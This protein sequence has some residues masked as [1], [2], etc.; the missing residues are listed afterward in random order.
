MGLIDNKWA[1]IQVMA[2]RRSGD[3]PLSAPML[4]QF[5]DAY[6]WHSG[7]MSWTLSHPVYPI[8][9]FRSI[10][11]GR[12]FADD[13]FKCIYLNLINVWMKF[14]WNFSFGSRW[15]VS[16]Y[17]IQWW[18]SMSPGLNE[19]IML[20]ILLSFFYG[21]IV[22]FY[23]KQLQWAPHTLPQRSSYGMFITSSG[24]AFDMFS[25]ILQ[26]CFTT[27]HSAVPLHARPSARGEDCHTG[28]FTQWYC[29][30]QLHRTTEVTLKDMD[31]FDQ[32]RSRAK[33]NNER[34]VW[35][36]IG[37]KNIQFITHIFTI[38]PFQ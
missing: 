29:P 11:N 4:T 15:H 25:R 36:Y 24:D 1:L 38:F 26:G 16:H 35:I 17:L 28:Y 33:H 9:T 31:K 27:R 20:T 5:T 21:Y 22:I 30:G 7:E 37:R 10:L 2:W 8:N 6:M 19:S 34:H 13:I 12:H 32:Y 3:N 18:P 14:H 23:W